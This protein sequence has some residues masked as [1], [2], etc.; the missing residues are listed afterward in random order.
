MHFGFSLV[1]LAVCCRRP[2]HR[3]LGFRGE[4]GMSTH[5]RGRCFD[6]ARGGGDAQD[7]TAA[8]YVLGR[9]HRGPRGEFP[10]M[11]ICFC[12][13]YPRLERG[14]RVSRGIK[15]DYMI[16]ALENTQ[17]VFCVRGG[18]VDVVLFLITSRLPA[19]FCFGHHTFVR[20]FFH[21]ASYNYHYEYCVVPLY[22]HRVEPICHTY[23]CDSNI[24][25]SCGNK[26]REGTGRKGKTYASFAAFVDI[27]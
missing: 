8:D 24:D 26:R 2:D 21:Q 17:R 15:L 11:L 22:T 1:L 9:Q 25:S 4:V 14:P 19:R 10:I 7:Q 12:E 6:L 3:Y 23:D 5:G 13:T 18:D 16:A 27:L 20:K